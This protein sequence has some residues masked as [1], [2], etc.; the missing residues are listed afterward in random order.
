MSKNK[1]TDGLRQ[2]KNGVWERAEI[3]N[4]KRRWFSSLDPEEVWKKRNAALGVAEN[5]QEEKDKG[6]CLKWSQRLTGRSLTA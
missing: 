5:E 4:G 6:P 3:I 2:K 1:I